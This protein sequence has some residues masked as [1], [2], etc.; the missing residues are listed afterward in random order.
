MLNV[1]GDTR[2]PIGRQPNEA[3]ML[4]DTSGRF[5]HAKRVS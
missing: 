1:R 3:T 5:E 2:R 4:S